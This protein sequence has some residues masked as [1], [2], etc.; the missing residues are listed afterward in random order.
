MDAEFKNIFVYQQWQRDSHP[1]HYSKHPD[2]ENRN[3]KSK[4]LKTQQQQFHCATSSD[5]NFNLDYAFR[6]ALQFADQVT[7]FKVL[8]ELDKKLVLS[9]FGIAF[10]LI[11]QAHD[12]AKMNEGFWFLQNG[13][14]LSSNYYYGRSF[15][16]LKKH[17]TSQQAKLHL[18]F[19]H[20]L[21]K[22]LKNPFSVLK[23]DDLDCALLKVLL[24]MT[25]S[26]PGK[27]RIP[28]C[29]NTASRCKKYLMMHS[30]ERFPE[31]GM[32]RYGAVL[33]LMG[34]IRCQVKAFYNHTKV[35]ELFNV[36]NTDPILHNCFLT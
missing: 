31:D 21:F 33:I 19:V 10:S 8:T 36:S 17:N 11:D 2:D 5:I 16:T 7:P 12:S 20:G 13:A 35:S 27:A 25:S 4:L 34:N 24:L 29:N 1:Q 22:E 3:P 9:E 30:M 6:N 32:I 18:D 15:N 23:I 28:D 26:F 14:V